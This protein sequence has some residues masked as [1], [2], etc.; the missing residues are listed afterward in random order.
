LS[1]QIP[2]GRL[3]I[4]ILASMKEKENSILV[5]KDWMSVGVCLFIGSS[6]IKATATAT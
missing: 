3:F 5:K 4:N 1:H 2:Q 6:P